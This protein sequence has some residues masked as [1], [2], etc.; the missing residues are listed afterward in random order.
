MRPLMHRPLMHRPLMRSI[1]S[2]ILSLWASASA[3]AATEPLMVAPPESVRLKAEQAMRQD[4]LAAFKKR[5]PQPEVSPSD[6]REYVYF[7]LQNG[8]PVLLISDP[9]APKAA[10]AMDVAVGSG[11]D[12][13]Q[14]PGLAHF[15]EHMLFLGTDAYPDAD[16][17][18]TFIQQHGGHHNAFTSLTNTNYFFDIKPAY[19]GGA[20]DRFVQFFKAPRLNPEYVERERHAVHSEFK[21]KFTHDFWR[22]EDV[23][24]QFVQKNHPWSHFRTGNL[25]SLPTGNGA[26]QTALRQFYDRHYRVPKMR[27]VVAGPQSLEQLYADVAERFSTLAPSPLQHEMPVAAPVQ[28]FAPGFLPASVA[29]KPFSEMRS[30]AYLFPMAKS[31]QPMQKNSAYWG[32]LLGHEG[33]GSLLWVLQQNGWAT[34]LSAGDGL[35]WRQ[36]SSF[37]VHIQ[38][39][40]AGLK[41][42]DR[43]DALVFDQLQRI[44]RDGIEP[45]R[46]AELQ[47]LGEMN[48]RFKEPGELIQAVSHYAGRLNEYPVTTLLTLGD[49]FEQFDREALKRIADDLTPERVLRIVTAPEVTTHAESP[50]YKAPYALDADYQPA[51]AATDAR[52]ALPK[53]NPFIAKRFETLAAEPHAPKLV[54][55]KQH[56]TLPAFELW[57]AGFSPWQQPR[58]EWRLRFKAPWVEQDAKQAAAVQLLVE[59]LK[60]ALN[61]LLYDAAVAQAEISLDA[62]ARG[63]DVRVSGFDDSLPAILSLLR[64]QLATYQKGEGLLRDRERLQLLQADLVRRLSNQTKQPPYQR[65][66]SDLPAKVFEPHWSASVMADAVASYDLASLPTFASQFLKQADISAL[67]LGNLSEQTAKRQAKAFYRALKPQPVSPPSGSQVAQVQSRFQY[68]A[69]SAQADNALVIYV[70]GED[71]SLATRAKVAL[72]GQLYATPFYSRL[73]TEQQLGYVVFA[74]A[75]PI[76]FMPGLIWVVQSPATPASDI[77]AA[78]L[79]FWQTFDPQVDQTFE[80]HRQAL[81][82]SL[83]EPPQN[84]AALTAEYWQSLQQGDVTFADKP[85][86]IAAVK[87]LTPAEFAAWQPQFVRHMQGNQLAL[88][89]APAAP[90]TPWLEAPFWDAKQKAQAPKRLYPSGTRAAKP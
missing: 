59:A 51:Q 1:A 24:R 61:P 80:V 89:A 49:R 76:R 82:A 15:L 87:A 39:T 21:A 74:G 7:E 40:P 8:L 67:A 85:A 14:Y 45:W 32:A 22:Q 28:P 29:I 58:A 35:D 26:L 5:Y 71:D 56:K 41:A 72:A 63:F 36:G 11:D 90:K 50:L 37:M 34:Q 75:Y 27:L 47:H 18:Q 48:F 60:Y 69:P 33:E 23:I 78:V 9:S 54:W 20:L 3:W 13:A 83:L 38:L 42:L 68:F 79:N 53:P 57:H 31:A 86:L 70:Q 4:L 88:W 6:P 10:A 65:L 73:R 12:P 25:D 64:Q 43:I 55:A 19:L 30:V 77:Y 52:L 2:A 46:Y 16:A 84:L 17:Y 81:L 66:M 62:H 44:A